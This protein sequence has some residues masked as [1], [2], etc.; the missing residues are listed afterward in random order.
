M[1]I[2][3]SKKISIVIKSA[4]AGKTALAEKYGDYIRFLAGTAEITAGTDIAKP[5]PSSSAVVDSETEVFV[6]LK[7]NVDLSKEKQRLEKE[8]AKLRKDREKN[9]AKLA[10]PSF[11]ER[12]PPE[13][14]EAVKAETAGLA[15][16]IGLH[17]R[18]LA[19]L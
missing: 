17:E 1:G 16:K 10:N 12:A 9:E 14:V 8:I 7:G 18:N 15:E 3:H 13:V 4:S 5:E 19:K 11:V 2:E 6:P